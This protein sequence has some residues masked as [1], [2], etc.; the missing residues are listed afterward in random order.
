MIR[1]SSAV[2]AAFVAVALLAPAPARADTPISG[3]F[4]L[5]LSGYRPQI[6]AEPGL[7]GKPYAT[8]FGDHNLLTLDLEWER[9]FFQRFGSLAGGLSAGYGEIYGHGV[10]DATG[11]T[12]GD[13]TYLKVIPLK[14]LLVYRFDV[15]ARR[16]NIPLVPFAKGGLVYELYRIGNGAGDTAS[17]NGSSG[18]GGRWG[19]E[20]D[21]GLA[22]M[23]DW[24]DEGL[25]KDFDIDLGV[26][27]S[28]FFAEWTDMSACRDNPFAA[29]SGLRLSDKFWRFGLALEY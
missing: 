12:S 24:F 6:D 5:K 14:A 13:T 17:A 1:A 2:L 26:N 20:G 15:L 11:T 28:Y 23:L 19:W 25:A 8:A 18:Q 3:A 21:L 27:H 4:E 9:Q 29:P 10:Y 7:N 22:L 16:M